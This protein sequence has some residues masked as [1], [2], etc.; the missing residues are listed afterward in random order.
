MVAGGKLPVAH[1][2]GSGVMD[3]AAIVRG[4]RSVLDDK[5]G[6]DRLYAAIDLKDAAGVVT[7]DRDLAAA[8]DGYHAGPSPAQFK[9]PLPEGDGGTREAGVEHDRVGDS[10]SRVRIG[11]SNRVP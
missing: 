9:L 3:A 8:V 10:A 11:L 4:D 5:P 2:Q 1:R 7:A 6:E